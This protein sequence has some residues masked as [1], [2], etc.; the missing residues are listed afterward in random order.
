[1]IKED[2]A[3]RIAQLHTEIAKRDS[4]I[5]ELEQELAVKDEINRKLIVKM[6]EVENGK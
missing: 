5:E 2:Q 3:Q 4:R 6:M 1:M